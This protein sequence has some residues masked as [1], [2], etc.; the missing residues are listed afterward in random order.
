MLA[1]VAALVVSRA[2]R[3]RGAGEHDAALPRWNGNGGAASRAPLLGPQHSGGSSDSSADGGGSSAR[4]KRDSGSWTG[5]WAGRARAEV[6]ATGS[7][8]RAVRGG[9]ARHGDA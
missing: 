2:R 4:S 5:G 9:G 6:A 8:L 1:A 7:G 3:A